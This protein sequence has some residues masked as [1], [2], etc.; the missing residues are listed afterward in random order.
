MFIYRHVRY[1]ILADILNIT[2]AQ[3]RVLRAIAHHEAES[4]QKGAT[5]YDC[6]KLTDKLH[7]SSS[8][9]N[10]NIKSLEKNLM[11]LRKEG[12][13]KGNRKTIPYTITEIG[14]IA[15]LRYFS[16]SEKNAII[17]KVFP[18]I[19][20]SAI[21]DIINQIQHPAIKYIK[22]N[23][24]RGVLKIALDS[25]HIEDSSLPEAGYMRKHVL[26]TIELFGDHNLLKTSFGR[27][28]ITIDP[29][30]FNKLVKKANRFE[31]F[32]N[33]FNE[34]EISITD[35]ITFLFYYTL[36]QSVRVIIFSR[37]V[38]FKMLPKEKT[39][40]EI[41]EIMGL[42]F[43]VI[44]KKRKIEKMINSNN[45]ICKIIEKNFEQLKDYENTDFTEILN[46]F[47]KK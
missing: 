5:Q 34:L 11:V 9:F 36:I 40:K 33:N 20:L 10:D 25:F 24:S 45:T 13:T 46:F 1:D 18:N 47:I 44:K 29:R 38:L 43:L 4:S 16:S 37:N 42:S 6:S 8:T 21:D 15:W 12:K 17:Q 30:R 35:R 7:I 19:Q 3:A 26:E 22:K 31:K 27:Y 32:E 2:K 23:Y 14:Q 39:K 41:E 28:Y